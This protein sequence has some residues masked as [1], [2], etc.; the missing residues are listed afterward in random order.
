MVNP[1]ARRG[2]PE[3]H[4]VEA[5]LERGARLD[6]G[7]I[8]TREDHEVLAEQ[9]PAQLH[10]L[11]DFDRGPFTVCTNPVFDHP[12]HVAGANAA[13]YS[14]RLVMDRRRPEDGGDRGWNSGAT[15]NASGGIGMSYAWG[16]P[17]QSRQWRA[18]HDDDE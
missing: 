12:N 18:S 2:E 14:S 16:R 11:V 8:G 6:H 15:T 5:G 10:L 1:L 3:E 4:V 13:Q 7:S 17:I 9:Q